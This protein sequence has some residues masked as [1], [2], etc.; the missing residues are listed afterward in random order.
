MDEVILSSSRGLSQFLD[1]VKTGLF[2]TFF[3]NVNC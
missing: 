1:M 2:F 3:L